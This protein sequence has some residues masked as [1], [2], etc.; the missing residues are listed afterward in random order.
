MAEGV[1][2]N[3][4]QTV[5]YAAGIGGSQFVG[6]G[7]RTVMTGAGSVGIIAPLPGDTPC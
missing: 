2:F 7:A 5:L 1:G 3:A 4:A 6:I